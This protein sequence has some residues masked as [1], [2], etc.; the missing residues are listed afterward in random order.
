MKCWMLVIYFHISDYSYMCVYILENW[1]NATN[2]DD[3]WA[4]INVIL[5]QIKLICIWSGSYTPFWTHT[6]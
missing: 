4:L 3:E 6:K 5:N 1:M 2:N